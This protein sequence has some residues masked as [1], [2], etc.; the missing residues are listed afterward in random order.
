MSRKLTGTV[1]AIPLLVSTM[2]QGSAP[3]AET[4]TADAAW[5]SEAAYQ[6]RGSGRRLAGVPSVALRRLE[7]GRPGRQQHDATTVSPSVGWNND[8]P[9][10]PGRGAHDSQEE[11]KEPAIKL[12]ISRN[13]DGGTHYID[14]R[15]VPRDDVVEEA[16]HRHYVTAVVTYLD[17]ETRRA[18]ENK[19]A[20]LIDEKRDGYGT[21]GVSYFL[22]PGWMW[23]TA[24]QIFHT[25]RDMGLEVTVCDLLRGKLILSDDLDDIRD[26]ER[27]ILFS[28]D[29][30]EMSVSVGM[31]FDD[32]EQAIYAPGSNKTKSKSK[33]DDDGT[34]P[35]EW[36]A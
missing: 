5:A 7:P 24:K 29:K 3:Q 32:G 34:P 28:V 31:S 20:K 25:T 15:L 4:R 14:V 6:V 19:R 36:G 1:V 8:L 12:A 16:L 18:W 30:I 10:L 27:S 23:V 17:A 26:V 13:R 11:Q 9:T 21:D 33:A 35:D 22:S 2:R